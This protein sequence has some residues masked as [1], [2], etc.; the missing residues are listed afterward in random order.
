MSSI[1][2]SLLWSQWRFAWC[3]LCIVLF[4]NF[5]TMYKGIFVFPVKSKTCDLIFVLFFSSIWSCL[6]SYWLHPRLRWWRY[7][8]QVYWHGFGLFWRDF[9]IPIHSFSVPICVN[10]SI[11]CIWCCCGALQVYCTLRNYCV[12]NGYVTT[13]F[14]CFKNVKRN[15][16]TIQVNVIFTSLILFRSY[17]RNAIFTKP[18]NKIVKFDSVIEKKVSKQTR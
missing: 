3:Y 13:L 15:L 5:V 8:R 2:V 10:D 17:L 12:Y 1:L 7:C 18:T 14:D 16:L 11:N 6:F 9:C 4:S